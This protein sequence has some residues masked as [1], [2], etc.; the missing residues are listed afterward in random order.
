MTEQEI[1]K[2]LNQIQ[3]IQ[4]E[5][6]EKFYSWLKT[7]ITISIG[8]FGILV[9]FKTNTSDSFLRALFF[10]IALSSLGLGILFGIF[11]LYSEVHILDKTRNKITEFVL[12]RLD[13]NPDPVE[14]EQIN[15]SIFF[16]ISRKLC[17]MFYIVSLISLIIY[18]LINEFKTMWQ[19]Y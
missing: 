18:T 17:Y 12:K 9:S 16:V 2:H 5:R 13:G 3:K 7:L 10:S 8:L 4:D 19:L 1:K 6:Q 15:P 11:L 14:F